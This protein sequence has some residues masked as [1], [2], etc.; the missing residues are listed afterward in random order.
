MI[1][2]ILKIN[3]NQ[4]MKVMN[5]KSKMKKTMMMI[6]PCLATMSKTIQWTSIELRILRNGYK[7]TRRK[8]QIKRFSSSSRR[9]RSIKA[10]A[11]RL[12]TLPQRLKSKKIN[13]RKHQKRRK[14]AI[15]S[16]R[17]RSLS[18]FPSNKK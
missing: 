15:L 10:L 1:Q 6:S 9:N 13:K 12:Q 18:T 5:L 11:L 2:L 4:I 8:K 16:M 14:K 3:T 17:R 7:K